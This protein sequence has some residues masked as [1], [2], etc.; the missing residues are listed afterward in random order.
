M[1]RRFT[2]GKNYTISFNVD[3]NL[4][5]GFSNFS[6]DFNPIHTNI[7]AARRFGYPKPVAHGAI[8]LSKISYLIGMKIPGAGAIWLSQKIEWSHPVFLDDHIKINVKVKSFSVATRILEL[9]TTAFNQNGKEVM[10]GQAKVKVGTELTKKF[11]QQKP[12]KAL[13]TGGSGA[14]GS[15]ICERLAKSGYDLFVIHRKE[16]KNTSVIKKKIEKYN[17]KCKLVELDLNDPMNK[18]NEKINN[19]GPIDVFVHC[20]SSDLNLSKV[21]NVNVKELRKQMRVSCE[22][23]IEIVNILSPEMMKRKFGRLIFIGTSALKDPPQTGWSSYLISKHALWGY[24]KNLAIELGSHGIT[25]N[26][27]SPSL[28]IS[29]FTENVS[30]RAKEVEAMKNPTRRLVV[31]EDIS[32]TIGYICSDQASFVNGQNIF[33]TGGV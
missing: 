29:N 15:A 13:L 22:S 4:I 8:L 32:E 10:N 1:M 6:Q 11:L 9:Y 24:V 28:T 5:E 31:P 20:A 12:K 17:V 3:K 7:D 21:E 26:M 25:A 30:H 27:I 23:A 19:I 33:L 2:V 18:W 14:I 16:N